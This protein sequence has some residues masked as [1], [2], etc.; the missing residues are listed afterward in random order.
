MRA[1][2]QIKFAGKE[3]TVK[4]LT[5]SQ[6]QQVMAEMENGSYEGHILD[7]LMDRPFPANALFL[8]L[9]MKADDFDL[10]VGPSML[11][12][13]YEAVIDVNPSCAAMMERLQKEGIRRQESAGLPA[14]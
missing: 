9:D 13:L 10:D 14:S 11:D 3:L 4:E 8:A 2:K 6:V 12:G 5:V 7:A 1:S